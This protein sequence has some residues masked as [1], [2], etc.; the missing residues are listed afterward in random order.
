MLERVGCGRER[1]V[2]DGRRRIN[3]KKI[4]ER[5]LPTWTPCDRV[6]Y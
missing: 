6:S 2:G 5:Y 4:G 3:K 1:E